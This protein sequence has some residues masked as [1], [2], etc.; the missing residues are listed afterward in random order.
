MQDHAARL[1]GVFFLIWRGAVDFSLN[2]KTAKPAHMAGATACID[3]K[4]IAYFNSKF[5]I[6][7]FF[8]CFN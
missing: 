6:Q 3:F 5:K 2:D 4:E 1:G 8:L 7:N